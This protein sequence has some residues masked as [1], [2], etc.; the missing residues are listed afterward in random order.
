MFYNFHPLVHISPFIFG[1]IVG[2]LLTNRPVKRY[3]YTISIGVISFVGFIFGFIYMEHL[4]IQAPNLS[5]WEIISMLTFGRVP[6]LTFF[7]WII[8]ASLSGCISMFA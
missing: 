8:Y 7:C 4:D 5:T 2:H 3:T 6:M 1:L